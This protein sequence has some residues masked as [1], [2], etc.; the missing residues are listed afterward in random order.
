GSNAHP[1]S[2]PLRVARPLQR[3]VPRRGRGDDRGIGPAL[4]WCGRGGAVRAPR[5][6]VGLPMVDVDQTRLRLWLMMVLTFVTGLVDAVGYLRLDRV[7]TGN[8][9][10]NIVILGMGLAGGDDL[11]VV[12]PLAALGAYV[13]GAAV[14]GRLVH[15]HRPAW[16]PVVTAIFACSACV[17]VA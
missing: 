4:R 12:G 1:G 7:F 2:R 8:M 14:A 17:L 5:D 9:T 13:A 3:R 16:K 6:A 11:P 15:R 10:G